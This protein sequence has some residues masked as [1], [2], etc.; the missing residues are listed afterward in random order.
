MAAITKQTKN[1]TQKLLSVLTTGHL[2]N[3]FY[4]VTLPFLLPT[5]IQVF[6]LSFFEAGLLTVATSFLPG[7]LQ[8]VVGF[9]ADAYAKNKI[10]IQIG[11]F[12]SSLG[13][14]IAGFSD[15][16]TGLLVAFIVFG[17]GQAT[18]HAQSTNLIT[19]AFPQS[20]GRSMGLHGIGGSIG[21]FSAPLVA[22]FLITA[23]SWR[24]ALGLLAVPGLL[25]ILVFKYFL[26]E[27]PKVQKKS[28]GIPVISTDL[29]LLALNIGLIFMAFEGFLTFLP[30][31]LVESGSSLGEA[32]LIA[33]LMLFMGFLAQ[34][35]GG[36]IYD[37]LGGRFLIA[38]SSLLTS[39]GL[40]FF[41]SQ[42]NVYPIIFIVLIGVAVQATYPVALAMASEIAKGENVG[43]SVGFVFLAYL[44]CWHHSPQ[45][46]WDT[47]LIRLVCKFP[48]DCW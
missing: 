13:L 27:P 28:N 33:A 30:T 1:Q 39:V 6:D 21:N 41:S 46:L 36:Y 23:L 44:V 7:L 15:S 35:G 25:M 3:D 43:A 29:L 16:Y 45:R 26:S 10:T 42:S 19:K 24:F 5:F 34:P 11:F 12:A 32:G 8:P 48:F 40:L 31:F 38:A 18:F 14:I 20:K 2:V 22:T 9:L 17:L 4:N 37:K 47:Q